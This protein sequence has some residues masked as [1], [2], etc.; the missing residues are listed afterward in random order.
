MKNIKIIMLP[1]FGEGGDLIFLLDAL[2]SSWVCSWVKEESLPDI[3]LVTSTGLEGA[4]DEDVFMMIFLLEIKEHQ[5][6][7]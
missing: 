2:I 1:F 4:H 7:Q 6:Q 5:Q 3:F